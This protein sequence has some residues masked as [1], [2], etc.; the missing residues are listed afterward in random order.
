MTGKKIWWYALKAKAV[1]EQLKIRTMRKFNK[2]TLHLETI[3]G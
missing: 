1:I 2:V 3:T